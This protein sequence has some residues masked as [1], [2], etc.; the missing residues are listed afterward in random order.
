[1]N[2]RELHTIAKSLSVSQVDCVARRSLVIALPI[3][4]A[5]NCVV[6]DGSTW[7]PTCL[8]ATACT[9]PLFVPTEIVHMTIGRRIRGS[10]GEQ[11]DSAR[12]AAMQ[13]LHEMIASKWVPYLQG[14][15]SANDIVCAIR[16]FV[17]DSPNHNCREARALALV[18]AEQYACAERELADIES[19]VDASVE[20]QAEIG[21]RAGVVRMALRESPSRARDLLHQWERESALA[22]GVADLRSE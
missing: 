18:L 1:M 20:W 17:G 22:L 3:R 8:Y 21:R 19:S 10:M 13:E 4:H 16:E 11:W 5:M 15:R 6:L 12:P 7:Q 2:A 14:I 9:I